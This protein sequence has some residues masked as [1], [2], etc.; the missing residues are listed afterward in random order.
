MTL[1]VLSIISITED[2]DGTIIYLENGQPYE[3]KGF[4]VVSLDTTGVIDT[5]SGGFLSELV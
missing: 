1:K 4:K 5:F 2:G 3:D